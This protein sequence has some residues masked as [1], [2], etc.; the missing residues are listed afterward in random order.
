MSTYEEM[1]RDELLTLKDALQKE[2][3][4]YCAL[5][6]SLNM[7]RGKP[8]KDQLDLSMP[9]LDIISSTTDCIDEAGTD[10]R[11]YGILDGIEEAKVLMASMLDDDPANVIV[12]GNSSLD[13]KSVV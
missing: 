11:N 10:L 6:L 12:F 2:Y 5:D 1:T 9:M 7:A 4:E 3:D 8:A 13:R